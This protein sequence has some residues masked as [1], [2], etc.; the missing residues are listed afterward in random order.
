MRMRV[1]VIESKDSLDELWIGFLKRE[2]HIVDVAHT[3]P[4]AVDKLRFQVWDILIVNLTMQNTSALAISDY[5]T[6]KN[7]NISIIALSMRNLFSSGSIFNIMPNLRGLMYHPI[8]PDDLIAIVD[9][10]G[11]SIKNENIVEQNQSVG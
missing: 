1:L 8:R 2:G 4:K 10:C 6:Y 5:A 9:H 7:P 3:Q 11:R